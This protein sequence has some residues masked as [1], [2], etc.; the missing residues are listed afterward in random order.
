MVPF[1]HVWGCHHPSPDSFCSQELNCVES[2]QAGQRGPDSVSSAGLPSLPAPPTP[3]PVSFG[4]P[5]H[6]PSILR[7]QDV[8]FPV[9]GQ[10]FH[11]V[12]L[13]LS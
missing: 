2:C 6:I 5:C 7:G 1:G 9:Q 4:I 3:T 13:S 8:P 11:L 12:S 10:S